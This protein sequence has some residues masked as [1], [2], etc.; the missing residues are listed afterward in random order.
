MEV[1]E[2]IQEYLEAVWISE[3]SG[4]SLARI[5][6]IAEQLHIAD[7]SAV[8]MLKK[9]EEH[10]YVVYEARRGVRLTDRGRTIAE[11]IVRNHR[12][13]EVLMKKTLNVK[14][15]ETTACGIEHHMSEDFANALCTQ[16]GHPRQCPHERPI[17]K[18]KC[19]G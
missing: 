9:L 1:S 19:C 11:R 15:D 10:G 5:S 14:V 6:W 4:E 7:P 18:G 12:L 3:E 17:P 8:E 16:L 13:I 2:N